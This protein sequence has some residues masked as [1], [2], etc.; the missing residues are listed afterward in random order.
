MAKVRISAAIVTAK[1]KIPLAIVF[2]L[3]PP[4]TVASVLNCVLN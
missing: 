1:R 3:V 4:L 2:I